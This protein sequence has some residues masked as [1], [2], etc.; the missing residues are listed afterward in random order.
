MYYPIQVGGRP[1]LINYPQNAASALGIKNFGGYNPLMLQTKVELGTLPLKPLLQLGAIGGI[2]TQKS[3]GEIPGF[4]LESFPPYFFYGRSDPLTYVYTPAKLAWELDSSK[5]LA[6]LGK[7]DF[8]AAQMAVFSSFYP[9]EWDLAAPASLLWRMEKDEPDDQVFSVRLDKSHLLVFAE[10]MYPGWKAFIDG[11]STPLYTADH[12]LRALFGSAGQHQ[13]EFRFDPDWWFP[14][15]PV[16][17]FG[18][19]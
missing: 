5:R 18:S 16:W 13:V 6:L 4:K 8:D 17:R 19:F 14:F 1:Y 2:L 11:V 7:S 12:S 10:V 3:R 15:G 9:P